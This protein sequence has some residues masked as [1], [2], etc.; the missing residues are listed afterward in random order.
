MARRPDPGKREEILSREHLQELAY[1]LSHMSMSA[2]LD[3]YQRAYRDCRIINS[4]TFPP[5][6]AVQ[7]LVQAWKQ[8]RKWRR[9]P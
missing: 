3:F 6:R 5:A 7:E 1:N 9:T 2:I 8:L 4:Q